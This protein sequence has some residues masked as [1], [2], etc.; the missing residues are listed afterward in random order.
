MCAAYKENKA[1]DFFPLRNKLFMQ[2]VKYG[3]IL[4]TE[5]NKMDTGDSPL[6]IPSADNSYSRG[7]FCIFWTPIVQTAVTP[8][9]NI[10]RNLRSY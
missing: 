3:T 1:P 7:V 8:Q 10:L 9:P 6:S 4:E 5:K 2:N